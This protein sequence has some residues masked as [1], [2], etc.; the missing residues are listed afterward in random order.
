[1][2][3]ILLPLLTLVRAIWCAHGACEPIRIEMCRGL[4]YN[5]TV[6]PNL[7]GHEI[8][9]D[10]D[11]TLQT[12]SPLIQYGCSAQLHLFLCSVYA[13]MCTEK[14]PAPIGPCRGLCEQVRARCFPVLQGFGFPWP[15]ALNCS[16]FPPENNHQ[17]MCMEGPGEPGPANPIQAVSTSNGPWGC[18]WYAKSGLYIF[19]N[20]SG[21]CAAACDADILWSQ[22]DKRLAEA[23]MA[24]FATVCLVSVAIA[25]LTLLKPRKRPILTT[26]AERAIVFLT[27]C[28]A[29]VAIGYVIRLA[30]GRLNV[31]CTPAIPLHPQDQA[32]LAQQQQQQ[33]Q[34]YL[35][36]D[37]LANPYCAVVFLLLYY[38][39]NAA[40]VW[41]VVICAWWCIMA[42]KWTRTRTAGNY[43][44][45]SFGPQ[46]GFSTVGAVA[47]WGLPAAHTI[48]VL[49]T[50]DVDADE[51]TASCFVGQQNAHSLLVLVLAPQFVYLS[52]G[53]T[54]LLIGLATLVLPRRPA[55][56]PTSASMSTSTSTS[57][58]SSTAA[59]AAAA[60]VLTALTASHANPL[61]RPQREIPGKSSP[62]EIHRRQKQ[63]L[64]RVGIFGC[65]YAILTIC[66]ASTTFYEWWGR[67]TWLRAP[68]PSTAPRI[69]A[70]PLLQFF[71]LRVVVT[72]GAGVMAAAWIWWPEVTSACRKLPH[73]K[74]PPHKCHPVPVVHCYNAATASS[75]IPHQ[76]HHLAHLTPPQ[77]PLLHQH[78]TIVNSQM[79][80][81]NHKK[82]R[83]HRKHYHSGSET[84]V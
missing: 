21:R 22:K 20:R 83:K 34:Q 44:E 23:W 45:D 33:Q 16:K 38:F 39:G 67:E 2:R 55:V 17:H 63:L 46:Q 47:A 65:L 80:H 59:A 82:H 5:V 10:A 3:W 69:P 75:P 48:A 32:V 4:G 54:F 73:C 57:S 31:A 1:M 53:A 14:V 79:P 77:H 68:E 37:G 76:I 25:I 74:Q 15:A 27:I 61:M 84:Q 42:R 60:A 49:V 78:A 18:S 11:F 8:Q 30:A 52:F 50:R 72:L 51:L 12:F 71:V 66:L 26:T 36:Q 58:S 19:L 6:M 43:K 24:V 62:A 28:H 41:W 9:G 64:T 35:T 29:A 7:V 70:R 81:R 13:P 40:I 56:T